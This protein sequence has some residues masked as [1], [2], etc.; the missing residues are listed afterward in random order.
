M[1]DDYKFHGTD[2][3]KLIS[4]PM[5]AIVQANHAMAT[6]QV[7][8]LMKT[9]FAQKKQNDAYE[10]VMVPLTIQRGFVDTGPG[11][12]PGIVGEV[13]A[14]IHVPL[15][16]LLPI[17]SLAIEEGN[18]QFGMDVHTHHDVIDEK[19]IALPD[20][21]GGSSRKKSTQLSGAITHQI[22]AKEDE[23]SSEGPGSSIDISVS[24][25]PL[26]LPVGVT[27][28]VQAYSKAIQPADILPVKKQGS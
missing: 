21:G 16:T 27:A 23:L 28:L 1:A 24:A 2:I 19:G 8:L 17:S 25:A 22:K 9:C 18:I 13:G 20:D 4:G 3:S 11:K 5:V 14:K 7:D 10:P 15:M 12:M 26:P 6:K